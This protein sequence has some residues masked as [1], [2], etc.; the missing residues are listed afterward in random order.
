MLF[1][2][3]D[4]D[5]VKKSYPCNNNIEKQI[6]NKQQYKKEILAKILKQS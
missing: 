5:K 6:W 1:K 3:Q 2:G 4:K